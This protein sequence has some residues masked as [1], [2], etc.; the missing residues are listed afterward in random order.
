VPARAERIYLIAAESD[1]V[2]RI[3]DFPFWGDRSAFFDEYGDRRIELDHPFYV[4]YA[5]LLT[6]WEAL[7]W[8]ERCR[9]RFSTVRGAAPQSP[10]CLKCQL[11][12]Q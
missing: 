3:L 6:A 9:E 11:R 5:L 4:D 8:D 12:V 7:A 1:P 10:A 2:D